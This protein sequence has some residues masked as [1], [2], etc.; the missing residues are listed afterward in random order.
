MSSE[1]AIRV[2]KISKC[3]QIYDR[4]QDRL[5]QSIFPRIYK[6]L[7][8]PSPN[9]HREFWA[10][11]DV[12]FTIPRGQTIGIIG[13]NGSG[14][15][16]L[17]QMICGTLTPTQG[18]INTEGRVAALLELGSGFNPSFTGRENVFMNAALLGLEKSEIEDRFDQIAQF[19]DIGTFIDEPVKN[20][21]SGMMVRLAFAVQAQIDPDILIVDEAL[22]VGDARFQA[23]CFDRLKQL[24][25][26]GTS[27]L[28][29]TH[30]S[31][32]IVSHCDQAILLEGGRAIEQGAPKYVVNRYHDVLFGNEKLG[33][34]KAAA[35]SEKTLSSSDSLNP[36]NLSVDHDEFSARAGYN[37]Y[38]YRW[39]DKAAQ[40]LDFHMQCGQQEYPTAIKSGSRIDL[41]FTVAYH[42]ELINPIF[43]IT[44][45]TKEGLTVYGSNSELLQKQ[46][47]RE[48]GQSK[49]TILISSSIE[50]NLTP[51]DYFISIGVATSSG[52]TITPRDRRYDAIHF[53]ITPPEPFFGIAQ[54]NM[55][56]DAVV[57]LKQ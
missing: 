47:I 46:E 25:S 28:L 6:R 2:E 31:E 15:S 21:S 38:E 4:P 49:S 33:A 32:Q 34:P 5:K 53:T 42:T 26:K 7:G 35:Q 56:I 24:K 22:A 14:K 16:T 23:K 54:L 51:G 37:P 11:R 9:Y 57:K 48:T 52:E 19:A 29:V 17:L 39:G 55:A 36:Q 3:Y 8:I 40:I 10:L 50:A 18:R 43:G 44:I 1:T 27:I 20:Y 13:R 41:Q 45:K 30:S 12:S